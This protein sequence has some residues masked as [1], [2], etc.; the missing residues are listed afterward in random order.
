MSKLIEEMIKRG[1]GFFDLEEFDEWVN[2]A[3]RADLEQFK[4]GYF[5]LQF[6]TWKMYKAPFSEVKN[7]QFDVVLKEEDKEKILEAIKKYESREI[8]S[9]EVVDKIFDLAVYVCVWV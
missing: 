7:F 2:D 9:R 6:W 5:G 8:D 4:E 3:T 1:K